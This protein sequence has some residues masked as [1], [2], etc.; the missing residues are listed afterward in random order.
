ME[1]Q[2]AHT[3]NQSKKSNQSVARL[4]ILIYATM[5]L[6]GL[7]ET[8]KAITLPAIKA[9]FGI[10]YLETG[11]LVSITTFAYVGVCFFATIYMKKIGIKY[12]LLTGYLILITG[13]LMNLFALNYGIVTVAIVILTS[14]FGMF[15]VGNNALAMKL[16][17]KRTAL[18][19]SFMH[20]FYGIGAIVGPYVAV[21]ILSIPFVASNGI[22][23]WRYIYIFLSV[24]P[25]ILIGILL[26]AQFNGQAKAKSN[27]NNSGTESYQRATKNYNNNEIGNET[28]EDAIKGNEI[29]LCE[30]NG[31]K[32]NEEKHDNAEPINEHGEINE[33]SDND[34]CTD[35]NSLSKTLTV[36]Q[37]FKMPE[38]WFF[39]L[40]L[41]LLVSVELSPVN[42]GPLY[43]QD[44]YGLSPET[45]GARFVSLFYLFF[46][47]SRL[48]FGFATEKIG[49]YRSLVICIVLSIIILIVGF[50][51]GQ[52]GIIII[53]ISGLFISQF[54]ILIVSIAN[55]RFKEEAGMISAII[56]TVVGLIIGFSQI[57]VGYVNEISNGYWGFR[58]SIIF[59]IIGLGLV[60]IGKKILLGSAKDFKQ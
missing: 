24:L 26:S 32:I 25:V 35:Y 6:S 22:S 18:L 54:W 16:F 23:A 27:S 49:Y 53:P 46:T 31:L 36:P 34:G 47:S 60:I 28:T 56:I 14:S 13:F 40:V 51:L 20:F 19:F 38:M 10:S 39:S 37:I 50:N 59:A 43:F 17:V 57:L 29:I 48:F 41:G 3:S 30:K 55:K 12:A 42:W 5:V 9:N 45:D 7:T 8:A 11:N 44:I 2:L 15:E 33:N 58:L 52:T 1:N 4:F 21:W